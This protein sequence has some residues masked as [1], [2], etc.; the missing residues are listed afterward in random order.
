MDECSER[1]YHGPAT[2]QALLFF[3]LFFLNPIVCG[4]LTF[5]HQ[6]ISV[7]QALQ[8]YCKK[9]LNRDYYQLVLALWCLLVE[10]RQTKLPSGAVASV[11]PNSSVIEDHRS[12][13]KTESLSSLL[14][15]PSQ[16]IWISRYSFF[17]TVTPVW[18]GCQCSILVWS[19]LNTVSL[20]L[21]WLRIDLNWIDTII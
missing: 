5:M 21:I 9:Y 7:T 3:L 6:N 14:P 20:V 10:K 8:N 2:L 18:S 4:V 17:L 13:G 12:E 1:H 11:N 19:G 15:H 16:S